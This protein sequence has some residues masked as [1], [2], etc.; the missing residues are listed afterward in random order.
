VGITGAVAIG[1]AY[2][3]PGVAN[4]QNLLG[5]VKMTNM[6]AAVICARAGRQLACGDLL[7]EQQRFLFKLE[8]W[9]SACYSVLA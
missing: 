2:V 6:A 4:G 8:R 1:A 7:Q 5:I 3:G 9:C